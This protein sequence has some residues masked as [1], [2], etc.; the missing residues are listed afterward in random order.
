[1][2]FVI[3]LVP[4]EVTVKI[5]MKLGE[6]FRFVGFFEL[7]DDFGLPCHF[8]RSVFRNKSAETPES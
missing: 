3:E 1:M 7:C 8:L 4:I 2:K 5:Y 6:E